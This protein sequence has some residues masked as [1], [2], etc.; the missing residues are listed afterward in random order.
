VITKWHQPNTVKEVRSFLG[1]AI[2]YFKEI[3]AR[4]QQSGSA[5]IELAKQEKLQLEDWTVQCG[6]AFA[7]IKMLLTN[8]P[9]SSYPKPI[10]PLY[11]H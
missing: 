4:V 7:A 2:S 1:L 6:E 11:G 9:V 5:N 10:P 3:C 8:V